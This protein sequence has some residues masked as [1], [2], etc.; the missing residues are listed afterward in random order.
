M[1]D[2]KKRGRSAR[3]H[4]CIHLLLAYGVGEK[5]EEKDIE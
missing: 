1:R 2:A 3:A 5:K 4:D